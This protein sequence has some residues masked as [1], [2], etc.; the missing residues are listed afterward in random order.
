MEGKD[1]DATMLMSDLL[2]ATSW[3]ASAVGTK[4]VGHEISNDAKVAVPVL[5]SRLTL[6]AWRMTPERFN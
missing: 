1:L 4:R 2:S 5:S 3:F 6:L